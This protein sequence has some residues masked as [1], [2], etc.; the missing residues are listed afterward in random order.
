MC[1][2]TDEGES[3]KQKPNNDV[4]I[5]VI[6]QSGYSDNLTALYIVMKPILKFYVLVLSYLQAEFEDEHSVKQIVDLAKKANPSW[7]TTAKSVK[8][9]EKCCN[10]GSSVKDDNVWSATKADFAKAAFKD[11]SVLKNPEAMDV[12]QKIANLL[13]PT[14]EAG[15]DILIWAR[16]IKQRPDGSGVVILHVSDVARFR[17]MIEDHDLVDNSTKDGSLEGVVQIGS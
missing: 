17:Q 1:I 7:E 13:I 4:Q 5:T 3:Q 14:Y 12:F 11:L 8:Y 16:D 9:L 2:L 10:R 15:E 6:K